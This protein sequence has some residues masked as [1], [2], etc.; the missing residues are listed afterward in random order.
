MELL[1]NNRILYNAVTRTLIR[2]QDAMNT[3]QFP[4]GLCRQMNG[5]VI[6][7]G[8]YHTDGVSKFE[9]CLRKIVT[10]ELKR[11]VFGYLIEVTSES[12]PLPNDHDLSDA[13]GVVRSPLESGQWSTMDNHTM[14]NELCLA[15]SQWIRN[16]NEQLPEDV[17]NTFQW[18]DSET[19]D[20][21]YH[22]PHLP[23][24]VVI[25]DAPVLFACRLV[26]NYLHL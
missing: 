22:L 16:H 13:L 21:Y 4:E 7:D 5:W 20:V 12:D 14:I 25:N 9:H 17:G 10:R 26:R 19:G 8:W 6:S 24:P 1:D 18:K 3:S 2:I 15:V 11:R 23:K